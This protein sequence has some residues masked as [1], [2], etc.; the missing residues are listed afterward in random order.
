MIFIVRG[1]IPPELP[2]DISED[3]FLYGSHS[4]RRGGAQF[5][6][7]ER[8]W[9]IP[10]LCDWGGWSTAYSAEVI[11]RYLVGIHDDPARPREHRLNP[12]AASALTCFYCGRS[13]VCSS[14]GSSVR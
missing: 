2:S 5:F 6:Y 7:I 8:N 4:F 9:D 11:F 14:C 10:T 12:L 3:S 1:S 13:P